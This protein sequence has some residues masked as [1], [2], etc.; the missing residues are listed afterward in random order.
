MDTSGNRAIAGA[1][2]AQPD[3]PPAGAAPLVF[4]MNTP[5]DHLTPTQRLFKEAAE[6]KRREAA[7]ESRSE[8]D[9]A[10]ARDEPQGAPVGAGSTGR[11]GLF[12]PSASSDPAVH[13]AS[14]KP[15]AELLRGISMP[16]D[17]VP[18]IDPTAMDAQ[19]RVAFSTRGVPPAE[20]GSKV[21]DELERLGYTLRSLNEAELQATRNDDVLTVRLIVNPEAARRDDRPAFPTL[22]PGSIVVE[23]SSR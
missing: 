1:E 8:G 3:L 22:A 18:V 14:S 20:V 6:Q 13:R 17:L 2:P 7:G 9:S 16:C 15:I 21:G 4:S 11:I 23:F 12:A 19:W 10:P 5:D